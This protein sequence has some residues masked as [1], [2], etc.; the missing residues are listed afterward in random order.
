LQFGVV[1]PAPSE[2]VREFYAELPIQGEGRRHYHDMGAFASD[3]G[4]LSRIV[5]LKHVSIQRGKDAFST[6]EPWRGP[7][8]SG[9]RGSRRQRKSQARGRAVDD[10]YRAPHRGAH[11]R[12]QP[13]GLR[14]R[15]ARRSEAGACAADEDVRGRV[16]PLRR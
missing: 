4:Q 16:E 5:T 14:R 1:K 13:L 9:R 6:M 2:T 10:P 3:V 15:G 8:L 12:W 7:S 11:S